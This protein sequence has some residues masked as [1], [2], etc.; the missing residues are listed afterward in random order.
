MSDIATDSDDIRG[1]TPPKLQE[2]QGPA[3]TSRAD[4]LPY[5]SSSDIHEGSQEKYKE[6]VKKTRAIKCETVFIHNTQ[7]IYSICCNRRVKKHCCR[8]QL[9]TSCTSHLWQTT[10]SM[11]GWWLGVLNHGLRLDNSPEGSARWQ[12]VC[13][14]FY[15]IFLD[16]IQYVLGVYNPFIGSTGL[17]MKC[18]RHTGRSA[19]SECSHLFL[20]RLIIMFVW[21]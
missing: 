8:F 7:Y 13:H 16:I 1:G 3:D 9:L 14:I 6:M 12:S 4:L 2:L 10:S 17:W 18:H 15:F 19:C 11:D 5:S 20:F 21:H